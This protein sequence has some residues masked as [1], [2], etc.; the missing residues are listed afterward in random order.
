MRTRHS[1]DR[2][3][4][5]STMRLA[6]RSHQFTTP[7]TV[8]RASGRQLSMLGEH[9]PAIKRIV[10]AGD[11]DVLRALFLPQVPVNWS[12]AGFPYD[13]GARLLSVSRGSVMVVAE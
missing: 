10:Q 2:L 5:L 1:R 3:Y 12:V 13:L 8:L 7:E 9:A 11:P 4:Q 6:L